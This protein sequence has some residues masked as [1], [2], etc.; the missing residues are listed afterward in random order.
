LVVP[1]FN[2]K[3]LAEAIQSLLAD[4]DRRRQMGKWG[5]DYVLAE[6]SYQRMTT[7]TLESYAKALAAFKS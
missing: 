6:F 3:A 5:R 2:C 4:P 7:L 1:P